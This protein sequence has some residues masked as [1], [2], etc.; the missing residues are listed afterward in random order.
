MINFGYSKIY[1]S[2]WKYYPSK[3]GKH[4]VESHF[5]PVIMTQYTLLNLACFSRV[6]LPFD[7]ENSSTT[8]LWAL[9][10]E[11]GFF[12]LQFQRR[13]RQDISWKIR[14]YLHGFQNV[15]HQSKFVWVPVSH[16]H[17]KLLSYIT[18]NWWG[19]RGSKSISNFPAH[20]P[21]SGVVCGYY[22]ITLV[23]NQLTAFNICWMNKYSKTQGWFPI[24]A[25]LN[26][27]AH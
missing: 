21:R 20:P 16:K 24:S 27:T 18:L 1:C 17:F 9:R 22:F 13:G 3:F 11:N 2:L 25:F 14:T 23:P 4:F 15:S 10:K 19:K 5:P 8:S 12:P 7:T 6:D 26:V